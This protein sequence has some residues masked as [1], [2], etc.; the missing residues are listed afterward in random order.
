MTIDYS[1]LGRLLQTLGSCS[2]SM[3]GFID[4]RTFFKSFGFSTVATLLVILS[5]VYYLG[6]KAIVP[7]LILMIIEVT[8]SFDNAVVNAK[9]L[10]K[11]SPYWQRLFLSVGIVIAIFGM[12]LV[13]P[14]AIVAMTAHLQWKDVID[15]ALNHPTAYA[16][17]LELAHPTITGFG[18]AFL[19]MLALHYFM[20][21][22]KEHHWFGRFERTLQRIGTWWMPGLIT[23]VIVTGLALM[24]ANHH[25]GETL[26]AGLVG[27]AIYIAINSLTIVI[28]KTTE[29]TGKL[30]T[31]VGWAA[32]TMFLYLEMLDSSFSLDGVLGAF[33][34]TSDVLLIV[35]GLGVGAV[36]VRSLTVF[37][38]RR[39][40][41]E[42]YKFLE[43]GAHY[44]IAV[45][46]VAML[47]TAIYEIPEGVTGVIGVGLIAASV[48]ASRK[49]QS[50][51][52]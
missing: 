14:I 49:A 13:F 24:P 2:S 1:V 9:I 21:A 31:Y 40:T 36:W 10:K 17:K 27:I 19:L 8:F 5:S 43:H 28:S 41:L 7:L 15:L 25:A 23:L 16:H 38:V 29:S 51:S 45:L 37:M 52:A 3:V 34:I 4:M 20:E 18:G 26:R 33:A 39:G 48:V 44:A 32:F 47:L 46:A 22:E 35:A 12:R 6:V 50:K 42:A 30:K 11:M